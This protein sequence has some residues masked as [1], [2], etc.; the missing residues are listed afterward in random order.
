MNRRQ[1]LLALAASG[2]TACLPRLALGAAGPRQAIIGAAWRGP[3][4]ND[5]YFAGALVADW[6]ARTLEIRYSV[7]LPTR[8]HGLLAEADGGLLVTGVRPGTWLLRCDDKGEVAQKLRV[9]EEGSARLN[10]H[11]VAGAGGDV[12]YATETDLKT[13]RGRIGVRDRRTLRKLAE[14]DTRGIDPHQ[15]LLDHEGHLMVANGGV[16]RTPAD[17]KYD[18][19]RMD[20]SLVRIDASSGHLLRQWRL[21][22]P[23]LSLRHL[24]WNRTPAAAGAVLGIAI[25]A[26]H[27]DAAQRAAAPILAVL[28]GERL[29]VPTSAN[30]GIGYA[31]DIAAAY[32]GG[33]ALSSNQA[34][35]AQLWHPG[36]PD[37]MAALVRMEEA[38]ALAP[39][40]GPGKGGG[41]LVATGLGLVRAHPTAGPVAIPWPKPMALDNHW[42]LLGES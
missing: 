22:D 16:P 1:I 10:G 24:A 15:L 25:Q 39:W 8:P 17:R 20:S 27:D 38:Y 28:D 7:P 2:V 19:Q 35:L 18:L 29:S 4:K 36:A 40:N 32:N 9:D 5:P 41:V 6:E 33:F 3:D 14:F 34:G 21:D 11:I 31:G 37:K 13:G 26:E 30:D 12:L 23:R 42:V